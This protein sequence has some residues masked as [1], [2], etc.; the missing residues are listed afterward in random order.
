ML[1]VKEESSNAIPKIMLLLVRRN[2]FY[3]LA[4]SVSVLV[5][6]WVVAYKNI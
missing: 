4:A 1:Q 5:V 6:Q 3:L 2:D